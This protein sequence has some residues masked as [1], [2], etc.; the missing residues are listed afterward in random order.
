MDNK[1]DHSPSLSESENKDPSFVLS[2]RTLN[3]NNVI[4]FL[5]EINLTVEVS[6]G[7]IQFF[8]VDR[9]NRDIIKNQDFKNFLIDVATEYPHLGLTKKI[10]DFPVEDVS[11]RTNCCV[12]NE[13]EVPAEP[14]EK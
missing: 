8:S 5:K 3:K 10:V 7:S 2:D 4:E 13:G 9:M 12:T 6:E 1:I 11:M 14:S